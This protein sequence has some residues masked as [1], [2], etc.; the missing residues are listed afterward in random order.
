[1]YVSQRERERKKEKLL[2][3]AQ[4][5]RPFLAPS[6]YAVLSVNEA[7]TATVNVHSTPITQKCCWSCFSNANIAYITTLLTII[8]KCCYLLLL[9]LLL[10]KDLDKSCCIGVA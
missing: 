4:Y 6:L 7:P 5:N 1:M 10:G 2:P 3:L 8:I 9:L